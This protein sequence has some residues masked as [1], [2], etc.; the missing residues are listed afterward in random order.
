MCIKM[1]SKREPKRSWDSSSSDEEQEHV[2]RI[3]KI[4]HLHLAIFQ[5]QTLAAVDSNEN[6]AHISKAKMDLQTAKTPLLKWK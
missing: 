4:L 3:G 5:L 2:N 1:M 6:I